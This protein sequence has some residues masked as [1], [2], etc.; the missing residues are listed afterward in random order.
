MVRD[1]FQLFVVKPVA[2]Y[3]R[4]GEVG[5]G[6]DGQPGNFLAKSTEDFPLGRLSKPERSCPRAK[7]HNLRAAHQVFQRAI[8]ENICPAVL[9][10][11]DDRSERQIRPTTIAGALGAWQTNG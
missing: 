3:F 7:R 1:R 8:S 9:K 11:P 6:E 2:A 4:A 10:L 5:V